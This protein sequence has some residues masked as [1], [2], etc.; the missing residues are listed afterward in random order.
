MRLLSMALRNLR[1]YALR[2]FLTTLGVVFGVASV[3]TMLAIGAGAEQA[4]L[5]EIGRLGIGNII[6]NTVKPPEATQ[7]KGG[8]G[9]GW[10]H[11]Y[12]LNYKDLAMIRNTV[13][14]VG[15]ALPVHRRNPR[16]WH[17]S[18]KVDAT[19]YAVK[20]DHLKLFG[21][22]VVRGRPLTHLDEASLRQV[23]LVRSGLI[24]Q[25][26]SFQDPLGMDLLINGLWYR[27]VGVLK[28]DAFRGYAASALGINSKT[29][30]IYVPYRTEIA[31]RGTREHRRR[32]GS[33]EATD[34]K[35]H[36]IVIEVENPDEVVK[37]AQM[38]RR[39]LTKNHDD[40]DWKMV[41][42]LEVLR[43]RRKT[44][45]VFTYAMVAIASISLLVGGIGIANIMLAT[46][47]ERTREIGIRRA[48]GAKRRHIVA[49]FLTETT[50]LSTLG[51]ILGVAVSFGLISLMQNFTGWDAIVKPISIVLALTISMGTGIVFGIFPARRAAMLDPIAALRHE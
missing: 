22:E 10:V 36:Q 25:L 6:L 11:E 35:L 49:Q 13:P 2:S 39:V 27:I 42:P 14:G 41:V 18:R 21:Y 38:V 43:Q 29:K 12:G 50:V 40:E 5:D 26:K 33:F 1:G 23:C 7:D 44:Q 46:V 24:Q 16:V 34:V 45:Q 48:L 8:G 47:T 28:D 15:R 32:Q 31:K 4:L 9:G 3:I 19:A 51:G 20:P 37:V 30:E 17:K